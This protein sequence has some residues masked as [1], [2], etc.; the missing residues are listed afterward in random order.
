MKQYKDELE[1]LDEERFKLSREADKI[2]ERTFESKID[3]DVARVSQETATAHLGPLLGDIR[4]DMW[5]F[6]APF[7]LESVEE[8]MDALK[9]KEADIRDKMLVLDEQAKAAEDK[10]KAQEE[11]DAAAE[12]AD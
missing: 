8:K 7:Y 4:R 5:T 6:A 11:L 1:A 12:K 9:K 2:E 3:R 10:A